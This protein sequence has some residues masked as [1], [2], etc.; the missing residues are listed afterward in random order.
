MF[1]LTSNNF[2]KEVELKTNSCK[3]HEEELRKLRNLLDFQAQQIIEEENIVE[4]KIKLAEEQLK[5]LSNKIIIDKDEAAQMEEKY[6]A[7][8][9]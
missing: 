8:L 2:I 3:V 4:E 9:E 5:R 6:K 1:L 7:I